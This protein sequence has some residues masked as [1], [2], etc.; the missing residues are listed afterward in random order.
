[1]LQRLQRPRAR[2]QHHRLALAGQVA[3]YKFK[4]DP[5]DKNALGLVRIDMQNEHGVYMHDT[6]MKKL[7][8]QRSRAF[9]A[10]CVRVQEV[11]QLA[12]W[13]AKYEPGWEQPGRVQQVLDGRAGARRQPDAPGARSTSP[14]SRRGRSRRP[15]GRIP[16]GHLQPRPRSLG[17]RAR[18]RR[19]A[20]GLGC[21]RAG[22]LSSET[23]R[24]TAALSRK[25]NLD[26]RNVRQRSRQE[27]GKGRLAT[28][29]SAKLERKRA[30]PGRRD[31]SSL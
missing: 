31:S 16:T 30:T 17:L 2:S 7:F 24:V 23:R 3:N 29:R 21:Q 27:V 25:P 13:I 15:A 14:T 8:E 20:A 10:G 12:E 1:M 28:S 18:C 4:Q 11:F 19:R 6:P 26:D 9:S 5:G 22:A